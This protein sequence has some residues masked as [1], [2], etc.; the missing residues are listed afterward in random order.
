MLAHHHRPLRRLPRCLCSRRSPRMR[1]RSSRVRCTISV[2]C[3]PSLSRAP[4]SCRRSRRQSPDAT[5]IPAELSG[6]QRVWRPKGMQ[7]IARRA[8]APSVQVDTGALQWCVLHRLP[9]CVQVHTDHVPPI[10]HQPAAAPDGRT[11]R[12]NQS[13]DPIVVPMCLFH[14]TE[15]RSSFVYVTPAH[16]CYQIPHRM[17]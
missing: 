10:H 14:T 5:R 9:S 2:L 15:C 3:S 6:T 13:I 16:V 11:T 17:T 7:K 12:L 1:S 4:P 8:A